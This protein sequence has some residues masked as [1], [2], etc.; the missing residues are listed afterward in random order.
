MMTKAVNEMEL[1][2]LDAVHAECA[3]QQ[4]HPALNRADWLSRADDP[5]APAGAASTE[6]MARSTSP[7]LIFATSSFVWVDG[8]MS[9]S[10]SSVSHRAL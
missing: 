9:Y 4:R 10:S 8:S 3:E 7:I 6:R 5:V 2:L 1:V